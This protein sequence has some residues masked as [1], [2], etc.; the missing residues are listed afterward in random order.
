ML[1]MFKK[2][3][4][5]GSARLREYETIIE[6]A[7]LTNML[8]YRAAEV[9][10]EVKEKLEMTNVESNFQKHARLS[11]EFE[12]LAQ[13]KLPHYAFRSLFERKIYQMRRAKMHQADDVEHLKLKYLVKIKEE[14]RSTIM[15]NTWP[16]YGETN[17]PRKPRTW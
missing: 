13:G 2:T 16:L 14:M 10:K 4:P 15:R 9:L 17:F 11:A 7:R 8:P 6:Q 12:N 5:L 1:V 3:L